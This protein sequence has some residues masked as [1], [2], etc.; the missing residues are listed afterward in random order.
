MKLTPS[1]NSGGLCMKWEMSL[2]W[3]ST[4]LIV[5]VILLV[6]CGGLMQ[7]F[8]PKPRSDSTPIGMVD[9]GSQ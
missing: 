6:E 7:Y 1:S 4:C 3:C 9:G 8:R 5:F 2:A